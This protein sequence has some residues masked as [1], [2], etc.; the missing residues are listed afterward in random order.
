M[1]R[2]LILE[3]MISFLKMR[4][5]IITILIF[6]AA[7][8]TAKAQLFD[9]LSNPQITINLVH[10]PT[11][12][13][14][15]NKIAFGP[16]WGRGSDELIHELTND[17]ANNNIEVID[18]GNFSRIMADHN[19][20]TRGFIDQSAAKSLGKI[21]G[22]SAMVLVKV[23]RFETRQDKLTG[24][25]QQYD[26]KTKK[27]FTVKEFYSKTRAF[28]KATVQ[29]VDLTTGR[30]FAAQTFEYSPERI[31]KS[32]Q[33]FP[34]FPSDLQVQ[35]VALKMM[36]NDVHRMFI[37]WTEPKTLYFYDDKDFGM[38]AAYQALKSNDLEQA[39]ALSK[40]AMETCKNTPGAKEKVLQHVNYNMGMCY[41]LLGEYDNALDFLRAAAKVK[42]GSIVNDAIASTLKQRDLA[43][44]MRQMDDK[45]SM[46]ADI[47]QQNEEKAIQEEEANTLTNASII[48][49]TKSK[50]SKGIIIQKIKTSK[51]KFD[52]SAKALVALKN[53]GVNE[54]VITQMMEV[55]N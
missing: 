33:G 8:L 26:P 55:T 38:K 23:Q 6:F 1:K 15:V 13:L 24:N 16:S 39:F 25:V 36:A 14:K 19:F 49:L 9:M 48:S 50:L 37:T 11:S 54:E 28:L 34:E 45:A 47:S 41:M 32:T 3:V 35:D 51:C 31:N 12:G 40:Q 53:A 4:K 20:P 17:F 10:P 27:N 52:T 21:L 22:P 5:I 2:N 29:T 7:S 42:T 30:T 43:V 46:D 18:R 44:A